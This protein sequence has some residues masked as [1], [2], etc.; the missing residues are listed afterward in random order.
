MN[1]NFK[2]IPSWFSTLQLGDVVL[3]EIVKLQPNAAE[4]SFVRDLDPSTCVSD[5]DYCKY[6]TPLIKFNQLFLLS[7]RQEIRHW[8]TPHLRTDIE[9]E[10]ISV[11]I[12]YEDPQKVEQWHFSCTLIS[13]LLSIVITTSP[14][15]DIIVN[16][17]Y[18]NTIKFTGKN[19]F[20]DCKKQFWLQTNTKLTYDLNKDLTINNQVIY[21]FWNHKKTIYQ[22]QKM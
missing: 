2:L 22:K 12:F 8:C 5:N 1:K 13:K 16:Y 4:N 7:S 10:L 19:V 20:A 3:C 14:L 9:E 21:L 6:Y 17:L 18:A 15:H 11:K